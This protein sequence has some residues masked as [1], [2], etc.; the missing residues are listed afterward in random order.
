MFA[1]PV[2]D[3]RADER[4]NKLIVEALQAEV[5]AAG[6]ITVEP[7]AEASEDSI[8]KVSCTNE[9]DAQNIVLADLEVTIVQI[10]LNFADVTV[11]EGEAVDIEAATAPTEFADLEFTA[12]GIDIAEKDGIITVD[13]SEAEAGSYTVEYSYTA[14]DEEKDGSF[15]VTVEKKKDEPKGSANFL[16]SFKGFGSSK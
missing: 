8:L 2:R 10:D 14:Y 6:T 4:A 9:F 3:S 7:T 11:T 1:F 15:T 5:D 16:G 12:E 13:A